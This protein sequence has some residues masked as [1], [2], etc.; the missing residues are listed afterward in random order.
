MKRRSFLQGLAASAGAAALPLPATART[1]AA[2]TNKIIPF[3]YG[4]ACVYAQMNNGVS[5]ADIERVFRVS[6]AD[7]GKLFD[8]MLTRGVIHAPGLDGRSHPTRAWQPWDKKAPAA[9]DRSSEKPRDADTSEPSVANLFRRVMAHVLADK[10][11]GL[12]SA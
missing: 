1:A 7:A 11:Y 9:A 2:A 8:R 4:W 12:A 3:H 5:P 10:S 6:P